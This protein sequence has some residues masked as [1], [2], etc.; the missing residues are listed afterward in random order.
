MWIARVRGEI[1]STKL[2]VQV[3]KMALKLFEGVRC[4]ILKVAGEEPRRCSR[5]MGDRDW[6]FQLAPEVRGWLKDARYVWY[7]GVLGVNP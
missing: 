2:M 5:R 6:G 1:N 3:L 4:A 7:L